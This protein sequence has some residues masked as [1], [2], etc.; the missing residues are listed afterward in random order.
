MPTPEKP[1][2]FDTLSAVDVADLLGVTEK[3]VRNW[4]NKGGLP[5]IESGRGRVISWPAALKWYVNYRISESGNDGKATVKSEPEAPAVVPLETYEQALARKTRAE[6]DLKELQL[7]KERGQ[8][9]AI[10]DVELALSRSNKETQTRILAVPSRLATQLVGIDE[11]AEVFAILQRECNQLLSS[12][13]N[14]DPLADQGRND[15]G[16]DGSS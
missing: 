13:A 8:V 7:G 16:E 14:F 5:S 15:E 11:R 12:L 6:A 2:K 3:T 9:A 1:K 4:M 10:A